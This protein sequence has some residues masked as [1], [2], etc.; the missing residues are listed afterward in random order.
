MKRATPGDEVEAFESALAARPP[1]EHYLLKLYVTGSTP[2]STKAIRNIRAL[3]EEKLRG[4]YELEVI[5][6]YQH[7]EDI[8]PEQIVVAPTLVKKLPLPL[9]KIIGDLSDEQRVLV[10]LNLIAHEP[11]AN[12][13]E[14]AHGT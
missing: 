3:C 8:R 13:P 10:G 5:D 2:R 1:S 4:R 12:P 9:R 11:L 6:I 14:K 7:P